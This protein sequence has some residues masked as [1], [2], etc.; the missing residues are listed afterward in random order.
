MQVFEIFSFLREGAS[1]RGGRLLSKKGRREEEKKLNISIHFFFPRSLQKTFQQ[2]Y[3]VGPCVGI[4]A[5][6]MMWMSRYILLRIAE[7]GR[8]KEEEQEKK[9]ILSFF[10]LRFFLFHLPRPSAHHFLSLFLPLSTTSTT[11][12]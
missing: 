10:F 9:F 2:E 11:T 5:G 7:V 12:P 4:D 8:K 3:Q 6:D 1:E